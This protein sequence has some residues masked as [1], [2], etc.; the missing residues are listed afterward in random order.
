MKLPACV[1]E[2]ADADHDRT[3]HVEVA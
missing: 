2:S 1:L 3:S